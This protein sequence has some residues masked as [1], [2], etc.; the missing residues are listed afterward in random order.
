MANNLYEE[1]K[2]Q[3]NQFLYGAEDFVPPVDTNKG[4][5]NVTKSIAT[6]A[7][8]EQITEDKVNFDTLVD[9]SW[10]ATVPEQNAIDR[11]IIEKAA[12]EGRSDVVQN[13][14]NQVAARNRLLVETTEKNTEYTRQKLKELANQAVEKTSVRNPAALFN[15]TAEEIN[16]NIDRLTP[17]VSA[18]ATLEKA[19]EDGKKWSVILP[20]LLHE[21]S[22]FAILEGM[23]MAKVAVKYGVPED[24]VSWTTGRSED[25][26]WLQEAFKAVPNEKKEEWLA[27]LYKDLKDHYTINHWQAAMMVVDVASGDGEWDKLSDWLDRL[28]VVAGLATGGFAVLKAANLFKGASAL[29]SA[30]R[31]LAAS[32]GKD[33]IVAAEAAK[34]ASQAAR[35]QQMQAAGAILGEATGVAAVLDLAKLVSVNAAKI[36]PDVVTTS[37]YDLQK[38]IRQPVEKLIGDLKDVVSAKGIRSTEAAEQIAEI[39][40]LYSKASNPNIHS[41]DNLTLSEDG[42]SITGKVYYKPKDMSS[43]L[44]KEAAEEYIKINDPGG[45]LGMSLVPDTTNTGFLVSAD[46]EKTLQLKKTAKEAE[47]LER[48]QEGATKAKRAKKAK[49][50]EPPTEVLAAPKALADS[51]PRYGTAKVNFEDDIDKAAYQVGSK[52]KLS[53]SDAEVKEWLQKTTGW[54]DEQI[55][56]HAASVRSYIKANKDIV[57]GDGSI[58]VERQSKAIKASESFGIQQTYDEKFAKL[59]S[60]P[61]NITINNVTMTPSVRKADVAEFVGRLG[62]ALGMDDRKILVMQFSDMLKSTSKDVKAVL[63]EIQNKHAGAGAMHFDYGNKQSIIV[64]MREVSPSPKLGQVSRKGYL[65]AFAHEYG[66]AFE[67]HFS[68]KYFP[69]INDSFNKWLAAKG[70]KFTGQGINKSVLDVFPPEA[71]LEFRAITSAE[72]LTVNWLGKWAAGDITKYRQYE[73]EIHKW[74]SSYSEFFAE[75]FA[76]WAFSDEIPT[77]LLGQY[78]KSIVN[79]FKAIARQVQ[80]MLSESGIIADIGA[81]DRN[82]AKMLNDHVKTTTKEVSVVTNNMSILAQES[83]QIRQPLSSLVKELNE[84]NEQLSAIEDA[85]KGIKTGWLV[86]RP[87]DETL[88]YGAIGKYTDEDINSASRFA[89]GDWALST[90]SELYNARVLGVHQQS[91]YQKLLTEFI[92]PDLEKLNKKELGALSDVLVLGDKEGK[93]FSEIELAGEGLSVNTRVAYFKVRA[94]RDAMWQI[95][96]D[97]AVKD[98]V[99]SGYKQINTGIK[100]EDGTNHLFAK[101]I[102][103]NVG[104]NIY[105]IDF[106][107]TRRIGKKFLEEADSKGF[108]FFRVPEPVEI[109]GKKHRLLAFKTG[110]FASQKIDTVIPYRPGEFRRIYSDEYFVKFTSNYDV[111]GTIESF[112][113]TH[114]TAANAADAKKYVAN[115]KEAMS[116]HKAG[117]LTIQEASRLM[118]PYNW[119]PEDLIKAFDEAQFGDDL[120]IK[121]VFN[122]T[123]DDYLDEGVRLSNNFSAKRGDKLLSIHG[124]DTVN[125]LSPLDSIAAEIGNTAYV[126]SAF[127]WRQ[128]HVHRWF[129]T[130]RDELPANVRNMDAHQ[131]FSHMLNNKGMYV[132]VGGEHRLKVAE[133]VQDYIIDQMNIPTKEEKEFLGVMRRLSETIEGGGQSKPLLKLGVALRATKDYPTWARTISFHSFFAFNP[134]QFFM[135]GMNAFNAVAISPIHGLASA[136]S[137]SLY[138]LALFSDQ[139]DIWRGVAKANKLTNLGLGMSEDEF[140]QVVRTIRRTGLLDGINTTSLYGANVGKY[141]LFNKVTRRVGTTAASPFNAGEGYSRL[142]SFDIARREWSTKNPGKAWWTDDSVA[143]IIARQDDLT[144][145][146]TRANAATWQKGWKSIPAQ[147]IQYPMKM[148]LNILHSIGGNARTFTREEGIRLLV[149]HSLVMGAAGSFLWPFRD[150]LM[151][152]VPE[153]MTEE[154]RL[155]VQ[156]GVIAGMIGSITDGD[157]KLALGTRFNTF[158][159]YEDLIGGFLDPEKTLMEAAAGPSGFAALRLLG[160]VGEGIS[161]MAKAPMT[162][163]TLQIALTEI[164]KGSLSAINNVQKARIAMANYN[165]VVSSSGG[166]M[167]RVTDTEAWLMSFGIPPAAQEDLSIMFK[168]AKAHKDDMQS[169]AKLISKHALMGLIAL[170]NN[171]REAF[172]THSAVVHAIINSYEGADYRALMKAAYKTEDGT[173]YQRLLADQALKQWKIE[174][175]VVDRGANK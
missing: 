70:I 166:S 113:T 141:G 65:E 54:S 73:G 118:Q 143:E 20:G 21:I 148:M 146:M 99:K 13:I 110:S 95:R 72:D 37:A 80:V 152:L 100:F 90:S 119:K 165:K 87:V 104:D 88:G 26:M 112:T 35:K 160:G 132:G 69:V 81:V 155:Y 17:K 105:Y 164:G 162:M 130:F 101:E 12:A 89:M 154:Q 49:A 5:Y 30:A 83:K 3:E 84:I 139:E 79:G 42:L 150:L 169:S 75:N 133:K 144:Q 15:N 11:N 138:A 62:K 128:S 122:R 55:K 151:D 74:A 10:R 1:N 27:N 19:I 2:E 39:E 93:V 4:D 134:V 82:I 103:P 18:L 77:T 102:T 41:V 51:K 126:A 114:R 16:N 124:E 98:M 135:Q 50:A 173:Q 56:S 85:K 96:N 167:Y 172:N 7:T 131:A 47:I 25:R 142:V 158:K 116:L 136:K 34:I 22:P 66:H 61:D 8:D 174:D 29:N 106:N 71:L 45:K 36:L 129:N 153:D 6:V 163:S 67:S 92:R 58:L 32:G 121:V 137:S 33:S 63:K 43:F 140:V 109:E 120:E 115:L 31:T 149:T 171:D 40:R 97:V 76:K 123:D 64:M 53:K 48:F 38:V 175:L 161:I 108:T 23:S 44:T 94:L 46:V 170:R 86:S 60:E 111:D 117:K 147:F 168:S 59:V 157:A 68:A 156:Q 14:F 78:F 125:T 52:T 28:G 107:E 9:T 145:N 159:Y 57:D 127:E 24:K 91:R